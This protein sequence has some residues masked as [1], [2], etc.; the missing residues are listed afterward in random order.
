M[1]GSFNELGPVFRLLAPSPSTTGRLGTAS[2][3][4]GRR[5]LRLSNNACGTHSG[6]KSNF[7]QMQ[8]QETVW[9]CELAVRV[10]R[11]VISRVRC[12]WCA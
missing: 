2:L 9:S 1:Y 11:L 4:F 10:V 7:Q 8:R 6:S 5:A 3:T 12:L